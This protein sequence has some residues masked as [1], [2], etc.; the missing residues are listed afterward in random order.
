MPIKISYIAVFVSV[1]FCFHPDHIHCNE[2]NNHMDKFKREYN[3]ATPR[4]NSSIN[5]DYKIDQAVIGIKYITESIGL[6]YEQNRESTEKINSISQKFDTIILQN[7]K[8]IE[9]LSSILENK[10]KEKIESPIYPDQI[11]PE[12]KTQTPEQIEKKQPRQAVTE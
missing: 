9:I 6:V 4:K 12:T 11:K 10:K 5:T 2:M 7:K 3:N 1:I 8:I